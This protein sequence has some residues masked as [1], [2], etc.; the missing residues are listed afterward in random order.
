V[1]HE[2]K[3]RRAN[4]TH[5]GLEKIIGV[6]RIPAGLVFAFLLMACS[7]AA[8]VAEKDYATKIVGGWQGTVGDTKESI[9]FGSDGKFV[10]Q[11]RPTGFIS[12]TLGQGVTGTISGTWKIDGKVI[13]LNIDGTEHEHVINRT[14]TSTIESFKPDELVVKSSNGSTSTFV[15]LL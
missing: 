15:R 6:I 7:P 5:A 3:P 8:P 4:M 14:T 10:T 11:V 2:T 12:N 9:T 13:T 1:P